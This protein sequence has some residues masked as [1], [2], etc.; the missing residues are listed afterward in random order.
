MENTNKSGV[1]QTFRHI[2]NSLP[3]YR[4]PVFSTL[5]KKKSGQLLSP[6]KMA[7][8]APPLNHLYT[9]KR[10]PVKCVSLKSAISKKSRD[11]L[12]DHHSYYMNTQYSS[13]KTE[14]L[15]S[16]HFSESGIPR[17]FLDITS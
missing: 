8:A 7:T 3:T 16:V 14:I 1:P 10:T 15:A 11:R 12:A 17:K 13:T 5:V 9:P 4:Q 2:P 6:A